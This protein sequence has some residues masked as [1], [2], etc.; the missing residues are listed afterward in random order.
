M[1]RT[2]EVLRAVTA[3]SPVRIWEAGSENCPDGV[4]AHHESLSSFRPGFESRSGR[5]FTGKEEP[6]SR[7]LAFSNT[8]F[9]PF[10]EGLA[11]DAKKQAP[12]RQQ[13][14]LPD[15][16]RQIYILIS[17]FSFCTATYSLKSCKGLGQDCPFL[18]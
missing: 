9:S 6:I 4:V 16:F 11:N 8:Y 15:R 13:L 3:M 12:A 17:A 1:S 2:V 7:A 5:L 14:G 18:P 10:S